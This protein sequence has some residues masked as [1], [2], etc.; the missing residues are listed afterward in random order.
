MFDFEKYKAV[1]WDLDDTLYNRRAAAELLFADMLK[2]LVYP[3]REEAFYRQ[4][5]KDMMRLAGRENML[6]NET[7]DGLFL[8]YPPEK[9][10]DRAA[11]N[12]Y[13]LD[14]IHRYIKEPY[15]RQMEI[16]KT[17]RECGIKNSI[18]TNGKHPEVQHRK[19]AVLGIAEAF[20]D[21]I[22]SGDVGFHKPDRRIY[23]LAA[24]NLGVKNEECLFVGDSDTTDIPGAVNAGMDAVWLDILDA[25]NIFADVPSVTKIA[26]IDEYFGNVRCDCP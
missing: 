11:C 5:A 23:D 7:L 26:K 1:L 14:Y 24:A 21:V 2:E 19:I 17:L 13:Y 8:I 20:D 3:G 25:E 16:V 4:A 10:P 18:V 12:D 6:R 15:A 9:E 22:V